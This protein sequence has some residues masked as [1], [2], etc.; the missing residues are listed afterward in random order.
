METMRGCAIVIPVGDRL[1]LVSNS[2]MA[3]VDANVL[4]VTSTPWLRQ[5][6][7]PSF[8]VPWIESN[9]PREGFFSSWVEGAPGTGRHPPY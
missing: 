5:V 3:A 6:A 2:E 7:T 9:W 4:F 8:L 1:S